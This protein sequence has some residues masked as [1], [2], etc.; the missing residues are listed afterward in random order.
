MPATN[1]LIQNKIFIDG[2]WILWKLWEILCEVLNN[3]TFL[4]IPLCI[5][6]FG[7][8]NWHFFVHSTTHESYI[9]V[10]ILVFG[11]CQAISSESKCKIRMSPI[12]PS[13]YSTFFAGGVHHILFSAFPSNSTYICDSQKWN[14]DQD[15]FWIYLTIIQY[16]GFIYR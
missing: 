16:L 7:H 8:C 10:T 6:Y 5:V 11:W 12:V 9:T 4:H 2:W 15:S 14:L 3:D 13:R 1:Q